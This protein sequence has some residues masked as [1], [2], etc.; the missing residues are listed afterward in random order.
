[1]TPERAL[2]EEGV[3]RHEAAVSR[4]T[5][6]RLREVFGASNASGPGSRKF[7]IGDGV[8]DLIGPR[9]E[10]GALASCYG[11]RH[12]RPV[13]VLTFDKSLGSNWSVPWHQ[14]RTI[15]VRQRI[16]V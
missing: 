6:D 8:A 14:D 12:V 16:D 1:M 3:L 15:A 10:M 2:D 7:A 9:G 5:I 11:G 13:R 4:Q